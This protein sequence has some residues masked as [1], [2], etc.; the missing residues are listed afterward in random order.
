[1]TLLIADMPVTVFAH[2]GGLFGF[3]TQVFHFCLRY[4]PEIKAVWCGRLSHRYFCTKKFPGSK[5]PLFLI[6]LVK[7][8]HLVS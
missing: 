4:Y 1:V 5:V 7:M 6:G 3:Q 2:R 8:F